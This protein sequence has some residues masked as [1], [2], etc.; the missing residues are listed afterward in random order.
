MLLQP[1]A[2]FL[3]LQTPKIIEKESEKESIQTLFVF[4]TLFHL[5]ICI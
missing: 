5:I 4:V 3:K 1:Q 2:S